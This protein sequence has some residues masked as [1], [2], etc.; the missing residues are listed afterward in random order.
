M[1]IKCPN[2]GNTDTEQTCNWEYEITAEHNHYG[3]FYCSEC[4]LK[5][6]NFP[7]DEDEDE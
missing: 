2:C 1:I 6:G 4:G 3:D 7:K 5:L